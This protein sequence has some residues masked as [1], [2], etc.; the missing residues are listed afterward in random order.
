MANGLVQ[1]AWLPVI[2]AIPVLLLGE[3]L[4]RR[5]AFLHR[6][7]IPAPVVGGLFVAVAVLIVNASGAPDVHAAAKVTVPAKALSVPLMVGFFT[8]IGLNATWDII[9][10]GSVPLVIFL[11]VATLLGVVQNAVGAAVAWSIGVNPLMGLVGGSLTMVGGHATALGF[12]AQL[13]Q[14]GLHGAGTMG[15]AAATLGLVLGGLLSGPVGAWLIRRRALKAKSVSIKSA[16]LDVEPGGILRELRKLWAMGMTAL[17]HLLVVLVCTQVGGWL[18]ELLQM[19]KVTFPVHIGSMIVGLALRNALDLGGLRTLRSD[20]IGTWGAVL[21]AGFLIFAMMSLNLIE[22]AGA[23]LPMLC[24]LAATLTA[25]I[26]VAVWVCWPLMGR[27]YEAAVMA[28]GLC[29]FGIGNTA[30]A[31]ASMKSLVEEHGPAPAA[32]L[33]VPLVGAMLGDLT[34]ALNIT[35]F[36]NLLT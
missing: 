31:V 22:L 12:A 7:S 5:I 2:L 33:V 29:G 25:T 3:W 16:V 35:L 1:S 20:V 18:S 13:E 23:A 10:R 11:G 8:C 30:N 32:F 28:A 27:D 6:F 14:G 24:I 19:T 34:N 26:L 9:R 36:L 15:A 4:V 17:L 21:L